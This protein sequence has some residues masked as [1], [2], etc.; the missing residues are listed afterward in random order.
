MRAASA[1]TAAGIADD[2]QDARR[3]HGVARVAVAIGVQRRVGRPRLAH[4]CDRVATAIIF[5]DRSTPST[6]VPALGERQRDEP[7]AHTELDALA[8]AGR[9]RASSTA[10]AKRPADRE[11]AARL[12]V[13]V[14]DASRTTPTRVNAPTSES[15]GAPRLEAG[16]ERVGILGALVGAAQVEDRREVGIGRRARRARRR[17]A[18]RPA[19]ASV[20]A[21]RGLSRLRYAGSVVTR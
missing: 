5:G 14:D 10:S 17:R 4:R 7:G 20:S 2:V 9:E 1:S 13:G 3:D 8:R 16:D 18:R 15:S 12:V 19:N 11:A 21:L 6:R